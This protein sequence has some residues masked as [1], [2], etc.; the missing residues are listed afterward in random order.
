MHLFY[1]PQLEQKDIRAGATVDLPA[2]EALHAVRVLRLGRGDEV[3]LTDGR[4]NMIK[5]V[6]SQAGKRNCEVVITD[7]ARHY[8]K[9]DNSLHLGVGPTKNIKRFDWFLEKATESGIDFITPVISFHSERREVKISRSEK[10][11]TAA[12]KQ[13]L[14]AYHPVLN[15]AV[16]FNDFVAN[17]RS[18]L[19]FIAHYTGPDQLL[20]KDAAVPATDTTVL[21]GPEGDFSAQEV[22]FALKNGFV[23]VSL[24]DT[25][26]RTETAALMAVFTINLINQ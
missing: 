2:E 5:A 3:F 24:G 7:V 11:I 1:T 22:D 18:E 25:R 19:K 6:V 8:G 16:A 13:S 17:C 12:V 15:E 4:G 20:L 9:R 26:L 14:K 21:V 10:V 23:A